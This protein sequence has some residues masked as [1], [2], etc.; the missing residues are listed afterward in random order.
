MGPEGGDDDYFGTRGDEFAE[1]FGEGEIP[2]D[3]EADGAE[4]SGYCGV[5]GGG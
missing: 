3:E 1:G 4:R 2:A 5:R